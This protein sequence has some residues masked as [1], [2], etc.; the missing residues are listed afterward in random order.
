[1]PAVIKVSG[2][3]LEIE[4]VEGSVYRFCKELGVMLPERLED[5][6]NI[7]GYGFGV[8]VP[9]AD[10]LESNVASGIV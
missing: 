7:L 3:A 1:M 6:M 9:K 8:L 10:G 2:T 4:L 5:S